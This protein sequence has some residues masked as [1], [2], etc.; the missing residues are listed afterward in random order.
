MTED[1][2]RERHSTRAQIAVER[3]RGQ[4]TARW[5]NFCFQ[6]SGISRGPF[7]WHGAGNGAKL[8]LT[9]AAIPERATLD[10]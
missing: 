5:K 10:L 4:S 9:W 1:E 6:Y 3:S 7:E 2:E 8:G